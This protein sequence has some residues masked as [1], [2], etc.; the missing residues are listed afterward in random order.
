M[1]II[2]FIL[3]VLGSIAA[4]YGNNLNNDIERQLESIFSNGQTNSG[5]LAVYIGIAFVI[6]GI[7]IVLLDISRGRRGGDLAAA[8]S[9]HKWCPVCGARI[10]MEAEFC[11]KCGSKQLQHKKNICRQCGLQLEED[12]VFCS[13]CG[14]TVKGA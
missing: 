4:I 6:I 5:D 10:A 14:A 13:K 8:D 1:I 11:C 7:L 9:A 3:I 2:G 12:A